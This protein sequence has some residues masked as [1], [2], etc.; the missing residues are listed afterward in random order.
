MHARE[1]MHDDKAGE[2]GALGEIVVNSGE[3]GGHKSS[4]ISRE[5]RHP[6]Y[7]R[8]PLRAPIRDQRTP[9]GRA[10]KGTGLC[11]RGHNSPQWG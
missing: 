7:G 11:R 3:D 10:N 9:Q 1:L 6:Y 4:D 5:G 8:P 2:L